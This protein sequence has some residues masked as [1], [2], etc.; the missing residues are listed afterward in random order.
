[1]ADQNIRTLKLKLKVVAD[2]RK[3]AWRRIRQI[4]DDAWR[5]A[6]WIATGQ[7]LNDQLVRR[8]YA[9]RKIDPAD[10]DAVAKVEGEFQEFFGTKRQ[11]TTERDVKRRFPALPPCVTNR[12][13]NDVVGSYKKTKKEVL[14]GLRSLRTY[15]KGMPVSTTKASIEIQPGDKTHRIVWKLGRKERLPFDVFYGRDK[16]NNRLTVQRIVS[17]ENDYCAA[18]IQ[19]N[20]RG[21]FLLL[22]VQEPKKARDLH[23]DLCVGADLGIVYPA[24]VALSKGPARQPIG[25]AEDLLKVRLHMQSRSRRLQRAL[26]VAKSGKGR[27]RKMRALDDLR[28]KE[29]R[30]VKTYS[31]LVS[32]KVVDFALRHRAGTIKLEMLEGF[33]E[34]E[35][36]AFVL[37][38]WSYFQLQ[39]MIT[40][41]ADHAGVAV[42]FVDPYHTSQTCSAC[43]HYELGQR[44]KQAEFKCAACGKHMNADYNA[45][46]N[47]AKSNKVVTKKEECEVWKQKHGTLATE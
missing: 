38:N 33:G 35:R 6:N 5:A 23:A 39:Q 18:Q 28:D 17:G 12:L 25:S 10:K 13:N 45:A 34:E 7:C 1:M 32:R 22:P 40:Y 20:D 2:D 42:C 44:L 46:V 15:R 8:I 27:K 29:A 14:A 16:A 3:A 43:G 26:V 9:R 36:N 4:S 30:Y 19:L 21:L 31:H 37:R 24:Y 11:A 41:K 47:I